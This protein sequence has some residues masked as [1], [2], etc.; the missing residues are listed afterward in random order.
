MRLSI[1]QIQ[2]ISHA[3]S[4]TFG[5]DM[6][7]WLFGSRFDDAKKGGDLDLLVCPSPSA[8]QI[9]AQKVRFP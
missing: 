8:E 3:A 9:F 1:D 5:N 7:G 4:I 6:Q 2:A